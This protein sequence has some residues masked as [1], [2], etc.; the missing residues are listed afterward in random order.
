M[1]HTIK[2]AI[3]N[4]EKEFP[5]EFAKDVYIGLKSNPK[6]LSS[7]YFYDDRGD[8]IFRQIMRMP[9]YYLTNSEFEIFEN[10]ADDILESIGTSQPF[11]IIELGAGDGY[12]TS[13]LLEHFMKSEIDFTYAPCDI[14]W[15]VLQILEEKLT[16]KLPHLSMEL[17]HGDYFKVLAEILKKDDGRKN[18]VFFLG[19]NIGNFTSDRAEEFLSRIRELLHPGDQL[20]IGFDLK[21]NPE[22]ILNAYNDPEGITASFNLNLLQRINTELLADFEV[23]QFIHRP[24]YDPESGECRSYLISKIDQEVQLRT[25]EETIS[26]KAWETIFMEISKKYSLEEIGE[27]AAKCSFSTQATVRDKRQYFADVLWEAI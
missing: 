11:R 5:S 13:L 8:E 10:R 23:D 3:T 26:F 17:L 2:E 15:N 7:K 14:S 16:R 19:A 25:I 27:L 21:K 9:S 1:H 24:Y 6:W 22:T 18:V 20:M 12:K 4:T